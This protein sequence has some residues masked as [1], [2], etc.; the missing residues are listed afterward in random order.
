VAEATNVIAFRQPPVD[1]GYRLAWMEGDLAFAEAALD[2]GR[3]M[4]LSVAFA[5]GGNIMRNAVSAAAE[6]YDT[7]TAQGILREWVTTVRNP[8]ALEAANSG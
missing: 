2:E 4:V 5:H 6:G 3:T 1:A 8:Q 7:R